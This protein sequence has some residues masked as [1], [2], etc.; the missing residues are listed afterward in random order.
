MIPGMKD[1]QLPIPKNNRGEFV[2]VR[3]EHLP[4]KTIYIHNIQMISSKA[5][6]NRFE[7]FLKKLI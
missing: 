2:Q 6:E 3:V 7:S 1:N 5:L 4:K